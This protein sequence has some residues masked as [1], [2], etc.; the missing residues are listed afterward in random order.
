MVFWVWNFVL[1][2]FCLI[3][4]S[5]VDRELRFVYGGRRGIGGEVVWRI[6]GVRID[7]DSVKG[8]LSRGKN[9]SRDWE[10]IK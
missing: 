5:G 1:L 10:V 6:G 4:Y 2:I 3:F 7:G 8:F 9:L